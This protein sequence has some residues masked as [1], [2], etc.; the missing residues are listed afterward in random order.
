M[1]LLKA[2]NDQTICQQ[3]LVNMC[4][5]PNTTKLSE[6]CSVSALRLMEIMLIVS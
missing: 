5:I 2:A 3:M 1:R 6:L 4:S